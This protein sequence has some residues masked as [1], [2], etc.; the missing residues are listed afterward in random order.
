MSTS[1]SIA[2]PD[3]FGPTYLF[4]PALLLQDLDLSHRAT[5][6]P[7][8]LP[9]HY[10]M[11]HQD[12]QAR[13]WHGSDSRSLAD[14]EK[15]PSTPTESIS[16]HDRDRYSSSWT[17][18]DEDSLAGVDDEIMA[19]YIEKD[20]DLPS[21]SCQPQPRRPLIDL[22]KNEWRTNPK[23]GP[24]LF[25]DHGGHSRRVRP[26]DC[27]QIVTAPRLRRYLILFLLL[28]LFLWGYW[29]WWFRPRWAEHILLN[30]S[31]N[32]RMRGG[33]GWYGGNVR[34]TFTDLIQLQTL[35][36]SLVPSRD[37]RTRLIVVGD[38]HGCKDELVSLLAKL[39]FREK[40]DHLILAGDL[41]SKGP[42]SASVVDLADSMQA[43][44]VRGNH[45]DRILLSYNDIH[46]HVLTSPPSE[47]SLT[48]PKLSSADDLELA[49]SLTK[50]QIDY[51]ASCPAILRVGEIRGMGEVSVVHAGLIPAVELERQDPLAVM[52]MRTVN[53]D[54]HIPSRSA[55]GTPWTKL[56]N[57]YQARLP[58]RL[59]STVIYGHDSRRGLQ[60]A[61]YSK[62][63]DTGCVKGGQLT[64][65]V[66][67]DPGRWWWG[68]AKTKIV[69][70]GCKDHRPKT[71]EVKELHP[72]LGQS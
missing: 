48:P 32:E 44:C 23:Y 41:V 29:K 65:M 13:A 42:F 15:A 58:R 54:T 69:S 37:G 3:F 71:E 40:H 2:R 68:G 14:N 28:C 35:D 24:T 12:R 8:R 55:D 34:P 26:P 36:K 18:A 47:K 39:S 22:V 38:V 62:G 1:T 50:A 64:A 31:L 53:L 60:L 46:S 10:T 43:S 11:S 59:R 16:T 63:L 30:D 17:S 19:S 61:T 25:S 21:I 51:L 57:R 52:T 70:V 7:S 20:Y 45:E 67:E 6:K 72:Q 4:H 66:I 49:K 33:E 27:G 5:A 9:R 56:W